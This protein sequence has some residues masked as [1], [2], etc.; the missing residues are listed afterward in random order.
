MKTEKNW[1]YILRYKEGSIPAIG[2]EYRK[3]KEMEKNYQ[4]RI[5]EAGK[6]CKNKFKRQ[7]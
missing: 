4:E 1:S 5:T 3:L 6:E 2:A 7:S